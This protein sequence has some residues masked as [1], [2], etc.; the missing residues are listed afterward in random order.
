MRMATTGPIVVVAGRQ[1]DRVLPGADPAAAHAGQARRRV[2]PM[3]SPRSVFGGD[4]GA[5]R[6]ARAHAVER[7]SPSAVAARSEAMR[8]IARAHV[9]RWPSRR[10]FR[11]LPR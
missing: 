6:R 3:A 9:A 7:F 10:P 8:A 4:D 1:A 11:L 5:H 2:L